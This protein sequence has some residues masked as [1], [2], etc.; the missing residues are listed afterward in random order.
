MNYL[1]NPQN[2]DNLKNFIF[3]ELEKHMP[4]RLDTHQ[5]LVLG[6]GFQNHERVVAISN[7]GS[8]ELEEIFFT[9]KE[10]DTRLILQYFAMGQQPQ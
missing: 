3:T 7:G 9:H 10:A 4:A 1:A 6:E 2:K 8:H 5:T